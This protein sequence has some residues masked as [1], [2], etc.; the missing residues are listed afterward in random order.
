MG[1]GAPQAD[2]RLPPVSGR[3]QRA[4]DAAETLAE[5]FEAIRGVH[6]QV[7]GFSQCASVISAAPLSMAS[8]PGQQNP[9][10]SLTID[11]GG[12]IFDRLDQA[13]FAGDAA[14]SDVK[15]CAVVDR[16]ADD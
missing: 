1:N 3:S 9:A 8:L 13:G 10:G 5:S 15:G 4:G 6:S 14:S 7:D 2:I 16:G 11:K 12:S